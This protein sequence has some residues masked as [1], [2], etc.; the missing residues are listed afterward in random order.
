MTIC[1]RTW[2]KNFMNCSP[3]H[4]LK[5]SRHRNWLSEDPSAAL[6]TQCLISTSRLG[7]TWIIY[8]PPP[9]PPSNS[10]EEHLSRR[11]TGLAWRTR[12]AGFVLLEMRIWWEGT[13]QPWRAIM[14]GEWK[15]ESARSCGRLCP[16]RPGLSCR[17][18]SLTDVFWMLCLRTTMKRK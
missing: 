2:W 15:S 6:A 13:T 8:A 14:H 17:E 11:W 10:Y 16:L 12:L 18:L 1:N 3:Q 7:R 5:L 4:K 9:P